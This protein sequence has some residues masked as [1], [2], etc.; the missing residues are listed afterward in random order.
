MEDKRKLFV[1]IA[2]M[3]FLRQKEKMILQNTLESIDEL[4]A[5]S[6][7]DLSEIIKRSLSTT[8]WHRDRVAGET[9]TALRIMKAYQISVI[10]IDDDDYPAVLREIFDPPFMLFY[11]GSLGVLKKPCISVVGTR[12]PL[13]ETRAAAFLF[14]KDAAASGRTVVSGLA[15][16]IDAAAHKGALAAEGG[17]TCAVLASGVDTISPGGN[18]PLARAILAKG[19]CILS[20]YTPGSPAG[21]WQFPERNRIISGLSPATV[22]ADAPE[23]SGSLI[24]ADFA[25]EQGRDVFF[26]E[27]ALIRP[28]E[29]KRNARAFID[30]GAQIVSSFADYLEKKDAPPGLARRE[31]QLSLF[32]G[33]S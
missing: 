16:G 12:Q 11:R 20:E 27:A 14:A 9:D 21:K 2:G 4:A 28:E 19:G 1:A 5:M 23:N 24:T 17:T 18:K 29:G 33:R 8:L 13:R 25:I 31:E 10:H 22:I 6:V 3:T 30:S 7:T 15:Y 32:E 26:H